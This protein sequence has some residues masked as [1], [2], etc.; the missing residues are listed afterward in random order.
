MKRGR[1]FA[2]LTVVFVS[3]LTL[4]VARQPYKTSDS[5]DDHATNETLPILSGHS[6]PY[7]SDA[8]KE[9]N[10]NSPHWYTA[11][12]RPEWWQVIVAVIG[13][14]V[15]AWQSWETRRAVQA[16]QKAAEATEKG[17]ELQEALN[18]QWLEIDG[19]RREGF[20]SRE[21]NPPHFTIA[22]DVTNS[23]TAKLTVKSI[24]IRIVGEPVMDYEVG[25][26]L[27][28]GGEP[29][30]I[31]YSHTVKPEWLAAYNN[32]ALPLVIDGSIAFTDCFE[33]ERIQEF[34]RACFLGPVNHFQ[35]SPILG[36]KPKAKT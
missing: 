5:E 15:I 12:K 11:L 22:V 1:I 23:T 34:R 9:A 18:Q 8:T 7:S 32:Y 13:I 27:A 30:K 20:G 24:S 17:V 19:W 28:P 2:V 21:T 35:S 25:N 4:L 10:Y 14:A 16:T 6:N 36:P 31:T 29:I 26:I 3:L 33:K